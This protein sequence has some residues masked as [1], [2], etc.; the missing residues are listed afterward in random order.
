MSTGLKKQSKGSAKRGE[1]TVGRLLQ[2]LAKA[3]EKLAT[4]FIE[5]GGGCSVLR[6]GN[7]LIDIES[8]KHDNLHGLKFSE[9]GKHVRRASWKL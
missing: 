2:M 1:E 6:R 9:H 5:G 7:F 8:T 3:F 4:R